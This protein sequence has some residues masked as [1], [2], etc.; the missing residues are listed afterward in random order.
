LGHGRATLIRCL[1]TE[2][3]LE[4]FCT[5]FQVAQGGVHRSLVALQSGYAGGKK[6]AKAVRLTPDTDFSKMRVG[7]MRDILRDRG[8][9]CPECAEKQDFVAKLRELARASS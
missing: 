7:Q 5:D 3:K 9:S 6:C 4:I 8:V 2:H 1:P